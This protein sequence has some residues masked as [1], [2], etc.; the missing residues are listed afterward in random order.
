MRIITATTKLPLNT[1]YVKSTKVET[2]EMETMTKIPVLSYNQVTHVGELLIAT[3]AK[4]NQPLTVVN[5]E[6]YT[7]EW[8]GV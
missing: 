5:N 7:L 4:T 8:I 2:E 6:I 1:A 3:K